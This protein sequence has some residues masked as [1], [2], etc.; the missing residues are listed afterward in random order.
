MPRMKLLPFGKT[1]AIEGQI[2]EFLDKVS[3]AGMVFE[4]GVDSYLD[5]GM[6]KGCEERLKQI[7][8]LERRG[9]ELR[10]E[11]ETALYTE[12]LIPDFRGD[13]L[14][15][16][17]DL[18]SLA[19]VLKSTLLSITIEK[20]DVPEESR[21]QFNSLVSAVVKSVESTVRASRAFFTDI[22]NVRE[23]IHKIGFYERE[24]DKI[25]ISMKKDIFGSSLPLERKMHLRDL[26]D[27]ID[28]L[29][30]EAENVGDR[31]SIYTIKRSP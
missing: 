2:D 27:T 4:L 23:H 18:D 20:H 5:C 1:K 24:A 15:L 19:D 3:E 30:D 11:I 7:S 13:V 29:A 16:L 12:L 26:V 9:D 28:L 8:E 25:A 17:E 14:S 31:L 10:R 21:K 6:D 22:K